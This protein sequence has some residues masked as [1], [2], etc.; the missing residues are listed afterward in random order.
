MLSTHAVPSPDTSN[1]TELA[2]LRLR[3]MRVAVEE[4]VDIQEARRSALQ[5]SAETA[6]IKKELETA[7]A[8]AYEARPPVQP[9][10]EPYDPRGNVSPSVRSRSLAYA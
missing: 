4:S 5:R 7:Q 9:T 8:P 1:V 3:A 6:R 10:F 2:L